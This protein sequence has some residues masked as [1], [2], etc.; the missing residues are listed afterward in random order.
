MSAVVLGNRVFYRGIPRRYRQIMILGPLEP[1]DGQCEVRIFEGSVL[2]TAPFDADNDL[3]ELYC[4]STRA[5]ADA[6]ATAACD[7][8]VQQGWI[9]LSNSSR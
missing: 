7:E 3:A 6:D 2:K 9:E 5:D 4:H 1:A 8:A